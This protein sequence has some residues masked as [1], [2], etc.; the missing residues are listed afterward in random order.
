MVPRQITATVQ[1]GEHD[2]LFLRLVRVFHVR[3][4][5]DIRK[6]RNRFPQHVP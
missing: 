3:P 1:S 5:Y 2:T 4:R 6:T